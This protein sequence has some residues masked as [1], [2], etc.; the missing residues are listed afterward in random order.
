LK[1][2][3]KI[4]FTDF[5][6]TFKPEDNIFA[7]LLSEIYD[8]ELD[9][10]NPDFL[11][12]SVFG[13]N[14]LRYRCVRVFFTG[15]NERPDYNECDW[16]FSFDY[17]DNPKNYRLPLYALF[18]DMKE[19]TK[20]RD[21]EK[22]LND[23][24]NFCCFIYSNPGAKKRKDFYSRLSEYK[25]IHSA[26]RY[27]NNIG[28]PLPGF[29]KEKRAYIRKFKFTFAFE[30]SS[31]P[32][33]TTEKLLDPLLC[34]S[35]PLYWGNKLA[36]KDFNPKSFLNYHDCSGDEEF[37]EKIIQ[38][39]NDKNLYLEMLSEP[40][41]EN[42]KI[43]EFVDNNNILNRLKYIIESNIEPIA[44]SLPDTSDSSL[45]SNYRFKIKKAKYESMLL[46]KKII[47]F[48]IK[49]IA[50]KRHRFIENLKNGK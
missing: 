31:Y 39:D 26:G 9:S 21:A 17:S 40:P 8:V 19:L 32:G 16:S 20:P 43:N 34:G 12:Y 13:I 47:D 35:I 6:D 5:W 3:I 30:N 4:H 48:S 44:E 25:F 24:E 11:F 37:I 1:K 42:N 23:K 41:F 33:Y 22:L 15:E 50:V 14:Y 45:I 29:E 18:A 27:M 2:K 49:K 10:V 28:G 46:K 38:Y 7:N 36:F